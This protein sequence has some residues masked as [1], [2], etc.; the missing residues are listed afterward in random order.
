[1]H[2][3]ES[4]LENDTHRILQVVHLQTDY[5]FPAKIPHQIVNKKYRTCG[6]CHAGGPLSEIQR[7]SVKM[8]IT[9]IFLE[10]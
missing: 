10:N 3:P 7:K 8:K 9:E 4:V 2:K 1:M 6:L 5:L